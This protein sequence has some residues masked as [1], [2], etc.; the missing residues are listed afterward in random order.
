MLYTLPINLVGL[1]GWNDGPTSNNPP[2]ILYNGTDGEINFATLSLDPGEILLHPGPN[3]EVS[4]LR[5]TA[6]TTG[7]YR[8]TGSFFGRDHSGTTT[9]VHLLANGTSVFDG[10]V[11]GYGPGTGPGFDK[12]VFLAAGGTLDFG[13]GYGSNGTYFSDST[14]LIADVSVTTP[15]QPTATLAS[16]PD[17][18]TLVA[19]TDLPLAASVDDPVAILSQ[20]QFLL[21]GAPVGTAT[22][23]PFVFDA[24]A[25]RQPGCP[26]G[27]GR[28]HRR[29]G[30]HERAPRNDDQRHRRHR[31]RRVA[32]VRRADP[33]RRSQL[34]P[35]ARP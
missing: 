8:A 28:R 33:A 11:N 29:C 31:H 32:H 9:D 18:I 25:A 20:V 6:P 21:D 26:H 16:P 13:V 10:A 4:L 7:F 24:T 3:G 23:A 2:Q 14:G 19:G 1:V 35:R 15:N 34:W 22:A 27:P 12:T 17:G 30:P 5:F